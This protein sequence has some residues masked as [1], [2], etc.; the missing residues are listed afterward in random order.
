MDLKIFKSNK[1]KKKQMIQKIGKNLGINKPPAR[2]TFG[3][4][5]RFGLRNREKTPEFFDLPSTLSER[6]CS[7][8]LGKRWS[9]INKAGKDA[10]SPGTYQTP[11]SFGSKA[12]GPVFKKKQK[13]IVNND[14]HPGPGAYNP[15]SPI[16]KR[17][18][19]FT[20]RQKFFYKLRSSTPPPNSYK[21]SYRLVEKDNFRKITFGLGSRSQIYGKAD[22][23]PGPGAYNIPSFIKPESAYPSSRSS[24]PLQSKRLRT[25]N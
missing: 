17:A 8:G 25:P 18:P 11:A 1:D 3:K 9:P 12:K 6:S 4:A 13:K 21:P 16:G 20:F 10:P 5:N 7:F 23:N 2:W 24:T 22:E 15:Y 19:K 14:K